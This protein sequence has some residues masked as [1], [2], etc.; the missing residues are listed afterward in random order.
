MTGEGLAA[1]YAPE[2]SVEHLLH[3][4]PSEQ[5]RIILDIKHQIVEK[6][7]E[8]K[9]IEMGKR[10]EQPSISKN[11]KA[12]ELIKISNTALSELKKQ[13]QL[14]ITQVN[15]LMYAT[16]AVVTRNSSIKLKKQ[17][18]RGRTQQ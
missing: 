14:G 18:T 12:R 3:P 11:R 9:F 17:R 8:T 15:D 16:A 1:L 2:N 10:V 6:L 7:K 5:E 4:K 13:H